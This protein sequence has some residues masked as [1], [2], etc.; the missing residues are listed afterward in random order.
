LSTFIPDEKHRQVLE[1]CVDVPEERPSFPIELQKVGISGK[2]VWVSL[3][4]IAC[5]GK[6][7]NG[8]IHLSFGEHFSKDFA[9]ADLLGVPFRI[10]VSERNL[11]NGEFEWKR[12]DTGETGMLPVADAVATIQG[13]VRDAIADINAR[14]DAY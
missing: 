2:T 5:R 14:A 3:S 13:W 4:D 10:I 7:V 12:R 8:R 9:D 1:T 6:A 11:N